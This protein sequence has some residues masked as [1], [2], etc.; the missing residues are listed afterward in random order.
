[1]ARWIIVACVAM[2][3]CDA[4]PPEI[5]DGECSV[6]LWAQPQRSSE[7]LTVRG[8][9]DDWAQDVEMRTFDGRWRVASFSLPPGEYG[10]QVVEADEGRLDATHGLT[11]F[12]SSDGQ[13]VS[14]LEVQACDSPRIQE[15]HTDQDTGALRLRVQVEPSRTG[16]G[17][18]ASAVAIN[19]EP[20]SATLVGGTLEFGLDELGTGKHA[21]EVEITDVQGASRAQT[22]DVWMNPRAE[23]PQDQIIYQVMID[24]FLGDGGAALSG[25]PNPGARAGGT[26]GG[27]TAQLKN[28]TFDTLPITTLWLSPVYVNPD[29][30]RA[31]TDGQM[32]EGYHGYWPVD[33]RGVDRRIGGEAALRELVDEAHARG[34][35]V[36]LDIVP[37]HVYETNPR[38]AEYLAMD[39]V[40]QRSPL[41]VC[42]QPDCPWDQNIRSCWFV[43]YLPD[44]RFEAPGVL[45]LAVEDALWWQ[46]TFD[47]DGFR[48]DA[49]PMMPRA[50][51]RRIASAVRAQVLNPDA[52]FSLGEIFTGPGSSGTEVLRYYLGPDAL[53]SAFDFPLMWAI[54]GALATGGPGFDAVEASLLHTQDAVAGSGATMGLMIGNHDVTRFL[55]EVVGDADADPWGEAPPI[56]PADEEPYARQAMALGLV[57]T[58]PGVP[59]LYYGDEVGLAGGRDP[60]NRR[61]MPS[62][63]VLSPSQQRL[64]ETT[65]RLAQARRCLPSLRR[66]GRVPL[67]VSSDTWAFMRDAGD[68]GP[69]VVVA[70]RGDES[71]AVRL[72]AGAYPGAYRDLVSG[73]SVVLE[74]QGELEVQPWSLRVL[75]PA[76]HACAS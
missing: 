32:Y 69:V 33:S 65:Q 66:G 40:H 3:G 71:Q 6:V 53:D 57:L 9:W 52:S 4:G 62:P 58:L 2:V 22:V 72:G 39:G 43:P 63:D 31:G 1:M 55:S 64:L 51:T 67:Y 37:N 18:D 7:A 23:R 12:R 15:V 35:R 45:E 76:A 11:R 29:E 50:V 48:V 68:A 10:Y 30:P 19:G 20:V 61:V 47:L 16:A 42:G 75:V 8:S 44:L 46:Q 17:L 60:D 56:Q 21:L 73:E 70:H 13:E 27:V 41:C 36:L 24:R 74:A 25:P 5:P 26:L 59:V 54:R 28:G 49:V 38:Y 14:W 34:I